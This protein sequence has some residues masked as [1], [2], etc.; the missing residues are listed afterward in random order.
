LSLLF[1]IIRKIIKIIIKY[2]N[3]LKKKKN[4]WSIKHWANLLNS[5]RVE[6][7]HYN[8]YFKYLLKKLIWI[9]L[10]FYFILFFIIMY[11][12]DSIYY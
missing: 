4:Y 2:N 6:L 11:L 9:I 5:S 10:L 12:F 7:D 8:N 3:L 1:L